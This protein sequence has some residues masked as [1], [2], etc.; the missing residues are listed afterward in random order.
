MGVRRR[1]LT[2]DHDGAID[3]AARGTLGPEPGVYRLR[4]KRRLVEAELRELKRGDRGRMGVR[5]A[6]AIAKR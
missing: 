2:T 1:S 5:L 4:I 3:F 6:E